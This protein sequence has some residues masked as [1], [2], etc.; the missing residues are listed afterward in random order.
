[1]Q[2]TQAVAHQSRSCRART[3]GTCPPLCRNQLHTSTKSDSCCRAYRV[4]SYLLCTALAPPL[5]RR[6]LRD[7]LSSFRCRRGIPKCDVLVGCSHF[8]KNFWKPVPVVFGAQSLR[9]R[10][11]DWDGHPMSAPGVPHGQ[12]ESRGIVIA[13]TC[14]ASPDTTLRLPTFCHLLIVNKP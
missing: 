4:W 13:D 5:R 11:G 1:M 8:G 14:C 3:R 2:D 6:S 7:I 9:E 12:A 10:L